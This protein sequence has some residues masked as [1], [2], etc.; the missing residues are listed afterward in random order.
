MFDQGEDRY[1]CTLILLSGARIEYEARSRCRTFAPSDFDTFF[2]QRRRWG[3]SIFLNIWR[4]VAKRREAVRNNA[5]LSSFFI[6]Y[7]A[8]CLVVSSLSVST[9]LLTIWDL[10][11]LSA[12]GYITRWEAFA[13]VFV[14]VILYLMICASDFEALKLMSAK[15]LSA[16]YACLMILPFAFPDFWTLRLYLHPLVLVVFAMAAIYLISTIFFCDFKSSFSSV[17]Y[18]LFIPMNAIFLQVI[19]R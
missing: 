9:V 11:E 12:V 13:V 17:V 15:V 7:Q 10:F 1:L 2:K 3:P 18:A 6:I 5:Y 8:F 19:L 4:L 16:I 14:P